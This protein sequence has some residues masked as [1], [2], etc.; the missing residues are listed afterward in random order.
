MR[1]L[2][3]AAAA[4][5]AWM[6]EAG[7][8]TLAGTGTF[9]CGTWT[10]DRRAAGRIQYPD[11]AWVMGFLSGV[12]F[13]GQDGYDPLAGTDAEGVFAWFDNYCRMHPLETIATATS[14]FVLA[15]THK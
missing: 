4:L 13:V 7:A 3:R 8:Y 6:P 15:H 9:S 14:K 2:A 11:E 10:A 5:M 12:G 1:G